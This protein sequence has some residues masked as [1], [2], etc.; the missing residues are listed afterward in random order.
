M[1][2]LEPRILALVSSSGPIKAREIAHVLNN[3]FS[4]H[5]D[6]STVNRHLYA[7]ERSG[8]VKKTG[9]NRWIATEAGRSDVAAAGSTPT[10][11]FTDDQQ[12]VINLDPSGNLLVR[13]QAGSG[14][15]TVLAARAGRIR[16]ALGAGD[17]LFLTYNG[18]LCQYVERAFQAQG[19][20]KG[21]TVSTFHHWCRDAAKSLGA[22][23]QSW[24]DSKERKAI[25]KEVIREIASE[26]SHRLLDLEGH[27]ERL[28]WWSDEIAWMLGQYFQRRDD[29]LTVQRTGRGTET[30]VTREDRELVWDVFE[31]Y[32]EELED[33]G[34]EDYDNPAGPIL[35]ALERRG[36]TKLPDEL[37]F[38]HVMIDEIQDFDRS[39][40]LVAALIPRTSLSLAG[41]LAQRIY[42]RSFTWK[43]VGIEIQGGR[44]RRL[45]GSHRTT[46]QIMAVATGLLEGD[47]VVEDPDYVAPATPDRKGPLVGKITAP[48]PKEAY[49][50]GYE[51][52]AQRFSRLR[53]KSVAVA[54]PFGRQTF[55]AAKAL[56]ER[57][58]NASAL[59]GAQLGKHRSGVA[60]TTYHQLKGLEFDHVVIF[61]LHDTQY[62]GRILDGVEEDMRA[63]AA[64]LARRVLYV[65]MTR[66]RE[67]VTLVGSEPFC[68]FFAGA[69]A[70]DLELVE[71]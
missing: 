11:E 52:V 18:A 58:C 69:S 68:R 16:S 9:L 67:S 23:V 44:S 70:K 13:G 24:I 37:R 2:N 71:I 15:T 66:A 21:V 55:A 29:Y 28:E 30:R 50:L 41:D 47:S 6:R 46:K 59:R 60:V 20:Q 64:M 39:W 17:I 36:E 35:R 61:G 31:G 26:S 33:R 65:A 57:R 53:S 32:A 14:K 56:K 8:K 12:A 45:G 49:D 5:V 25:L 51:F 4:G 38:D 43:S 7:M 19:L 10:I 27:Q 63:D 54:L 42:R 62:P 40:L 34:A 48:T 22:E 1:E 3:E